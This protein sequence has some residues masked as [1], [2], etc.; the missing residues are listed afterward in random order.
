MLNMLKHVSIIYNSM[1]MKH[2]PS[3]PS[4]TNI[5]T[6]KS[7]QASTFPEKVVI[8]MD[9]MRSSFSTNKRQCFKY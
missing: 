9:V 4:H 3:S 2:M 1:L 8:R 6:C 7:A 5:P